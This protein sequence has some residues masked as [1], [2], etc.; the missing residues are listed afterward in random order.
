MLTLRVIPPRLMPPGNEGRHQA[1][2]IAALYFGRLWLHWRWR[3]R[4][5]ALLLATGGMARGLRGMATANPGWRNGW[6]MAEQALLAPAGDGAAHLGMAARKGV[7]RLLNPGAFPFAANPLKNKRLFALRCRQS[8]LPVPDTF[9]GSEEQLVRWALARNALIVK[10]NY[11]SK[12]HGIV[13]YIRVPGGWQTCSSGQISDSRL[14][15][16]LVRA[17]R[18]GAVI[19]QAMATHPDLATLSPGALPSLRIM[20]CLDEAGAIEVCGLVLR[21]CAGGARPVDNFNAGNLVAAVD[22]AG[23]CGPAIW[24]QDG[25]IVS[26]DRHPATHAVI[27][28]KLLPDIASATALAIAAHQAFRE[29]FTVIG[30]DIGL[31]ADGPILIEGNWNPGTDILQLVSGTGLGE[32]RLGALYHHHLA[33]LPRS[34]WRNARPIQAEPRHAPRLRREPAHGR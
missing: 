20:T 1:N 4:L 22:D 7:H 12:G 5:I 2:D 9:D 21:L 11:S 17:H 29:G 8:T 13:R 14:A 24:R 26:T 34:R 3:D 28:G 33:T 16:R 27:R 25:R 23:R 19:Q 30:W 31:T 32:T 6:N 18:A 10:P 15:D